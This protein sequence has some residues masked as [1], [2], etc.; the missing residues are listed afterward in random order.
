MDNKRDVFVEPTG[1]SNRMPLGKSDLAWTDFAAG[2]ASTKESRMRAS[3][4]SKANPSARSIASQL[5]MGGSDSTDIGGATDSDKHR[6]SEGIDR[7]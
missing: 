7:R 5:Y 3:G 4:G 6:A 2:V 1:P